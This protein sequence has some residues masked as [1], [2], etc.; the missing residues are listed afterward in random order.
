MKKVIMKMIRIDEYGYDYCSVFFEIL[1]PLV[2][3]SDET[4][5]MEIRAVPKYADIHTSCG[6]NILFTISVFTNCKYEY[7]RTVNGI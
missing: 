6:C 4:G 2:S 5:L 7:V 1:F 3:H